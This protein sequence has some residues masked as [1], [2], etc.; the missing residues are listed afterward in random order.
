MVICRN[1]HE[2]KQISQ[3]RMMKIKF[4]LCQEKSKE[5]DRGLNSSW[6]FQC[7]NRMIE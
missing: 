5:K 2:Q 1:D 7:V 6:G 3:K 4:S